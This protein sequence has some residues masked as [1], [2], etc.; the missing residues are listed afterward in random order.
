MFA[1]LSLVP[2]PW[3]IATLRL[4][5]AAVSWSTPTMRK[6]SACAARANQL[7]W[8]PAATGTVGVAFGLASAIAKSTPEIERPIAAGLSFVGSPSIS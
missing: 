6:S 5:I 3:L 1:T 8:S 2:P 7:R 4:L